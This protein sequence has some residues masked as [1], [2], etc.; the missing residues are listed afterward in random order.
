MDTSGIVVIALLVGA[1][2]VVAFLY[3]RGSFEAGMEALGAKLNLKGRGQPE[4]EPSNPA[5][6]APSAPLQAAPTGART[7]RGPARSRSAAA[8]IRPRSAPRSSAGD[9]PMLGRLVP[10]DAPGAV[11]QRERGAAPWPTPRRHPLVRS[12]AAPPP[13]ASVAD[14]DRRPDRAPTSMST[15]SWQRERS[16]EDLLGRRASGDSLPA[17]LGDF[18]GRVKEIERLEA[19]LTRGGGQAAVT[20]IG[21]MGGVGK[22]ALA[23]HV[24]H[25]LENEAPDGRVFVD[26]AGRTGTPF[27]VARRAGAR[28]TVR[29]DRGDA[30][31]GR[32][33][34]SRQQV[35]KEADAAA[36][37]YRAALD[38]KR[39]LLLLDNAEDSAQVRPLLDWRAPTTMVV[40]TSRRTIAAPGLHG[41][42]PRRDGTERRADAAADGARG[43]RR[44][45]RRA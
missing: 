1:I 32:G 5:A 39:V 33:A 31:G 40:V 12:R 9:S 36:R 11:P 23:V 8:P 16:L 44:E 37:A 7:H 41:D 25:L 26:M 30:E 27:A 18:E 21:G 3:R 42:R 19:I 24:A 22:S 15:T 38:G 6:P 4:A 28:R 2:L 43:A 17:D 29:V 10:D 14:A 45:R 20:A 34:R 13:S 35:A